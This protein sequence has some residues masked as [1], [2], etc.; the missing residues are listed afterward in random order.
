MSPP[1]CCQFQACLPVSCGKGEAQMSPWISGVSPPKSVSEPSK[2]MC[3]AR[4]IQRRRKTCSCDG[5]VGGV[6]TKT[7]GRSGL[8]EDVEKKA[9]AARKL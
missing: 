5:Y 4:N 8:E 1:L 9:K 2:V 3:Q 7:R 6:D